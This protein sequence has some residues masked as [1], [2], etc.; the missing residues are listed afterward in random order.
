MG[1]PRQG[2]LPVLLQTQGG[3]GQSLGHPEGQ[4]QEDDISEDGAGSAQLWQD[5]GGQKD[6]EEAN[7]PVQW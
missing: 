2:Q 6:Q 5:R 4:S 7:L 3:S 1:G